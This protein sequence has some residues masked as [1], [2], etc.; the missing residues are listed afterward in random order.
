MKEIIKKLKKA[1]EY[2]IFVV[3]DS[4]TEGA[5]ATD[6]DHTYTAA[7]AR[8]LAKEFPA[9]TILR[10]DGKRF[11]HPDAE[12]MN[13]QA[14]EG[15]Y[16]VQSGEE[17][18][19]TIVRNGLGGN[20]A[21]RLLKRKN[22]YIGKEF[23]GRTADL[24]ILMLGINDSIQTNPEKYAE[25]QV[26]YEDLENL[27]KALREGNPKADLI[28]MTP[29]YNDYGREA[30]S[31]VSPYAEEMRRLCQKHALPLVDQ[32]RL[33]MDHLQIGAINDG[34]GDWLTGQKGDHCHPSNIGH[35][36]IA[37]ELLRCLFSL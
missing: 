33:W 9:R 30:I 35:Q 37:D 14:F 5:R 25:P 26:F 18:T 29:T 31:T 4:I 36:A 22:D 1:K 20:T 27:L 28:F 17:G 23:D 3:G 13:L 19:I 32:H 16:R 10:Y 12:K 11:D 34:Q 6:D 24:Y 2:T 7:F 21:K 8:G 15:P